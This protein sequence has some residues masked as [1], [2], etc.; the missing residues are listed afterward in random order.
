MSFD[1]VNARRSVRRRFLTPR[2]EASGT[3]NQQERQ[4]LRWLYSGLLLTIVAGDLVIY[5]ATGT[6]GDNYIGIPI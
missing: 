2:P 1:T 3:F 5:V 4:Q 6:P